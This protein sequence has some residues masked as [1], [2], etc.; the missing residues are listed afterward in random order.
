[1]NIHRRA[2]PSLLCLLLL[3]SCAPAPE[4][5]TPGP[6]AGKAA[7][8]ARSVVVSYVEGEVSIDGKPAEPGQSPGLSFTVA[9]GPAARCVIVFDGGNALSVGQNALAAFD[10]L[11]LTPKVRLDKGGLTSVLKKLE[12]AAGKDGFIVESSSAVASVRGTSFCVWVDETSSYVCACNGSV[13]TIDG[14][15]SREEDLSASHHVARLFTTRPE[16]ISVEPAAMLH[17]SDESV[18]AVASAVGWTIDWGKVDH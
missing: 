8:P 11:A 1:M 14:K 2:L 18:Q 7:A 9:T 13:H 16:G 6:A 5:R 17:H 10:L 12:K 4:G 3:A 15:G